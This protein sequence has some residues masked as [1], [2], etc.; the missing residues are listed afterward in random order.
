MEPTNLDI[1]AC[2]RNLFC[3]NTGSKIEGVWEQT[4]EENVSTKGEG[5]DRKTEEIKYLSPNITEDL[6]SRMIW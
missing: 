6:K 1:F 3:P 2:L 5:S 4:A